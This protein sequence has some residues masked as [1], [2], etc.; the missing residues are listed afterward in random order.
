M[1][2]WPDKGDA[3]AMAAA[4]AANPPQDGVRAG[5]KKKKLILIAAPLLL[6]LAAGGAFLLGLIPGTGQPAA[7][8]AAEAAPAPVNRQPVF[9]AMP[10]ITANLNAPRPPRRLYPPQ[11]PDRGRRPGGR[12]A[13]QAAMPRIVDLFTTYLREVRPEELRGSA[14]THRLREELPRAPTSPPPPPASPTSCS[15]R[16]SSSERG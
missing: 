3:G 14:G 5:S 6:L 13:L 7:A 1:L 12:R 8:P 2:P 9:V 11:K 16:S 4:E 15:Q 10:E